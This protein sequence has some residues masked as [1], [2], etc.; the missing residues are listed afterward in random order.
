MEPQSHAPAEPLLSLAQQKFYASER[1]DDARRMLQ[2]LV[3]NTSF[4]TK[5]QYY[6]GVSDF[7]ERHLNY[8]SKQPKL[9]IMGYI[10]N[11]RLMTR[12]RG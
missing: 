1:C 11:L 10:S 9:D 6:E 8:L 12:R 4:D 5:S 7:I 2:E 3:D